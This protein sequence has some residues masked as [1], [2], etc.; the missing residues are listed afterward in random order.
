QRNDESREGTERSTPACQ[1]VPDQPPPRLTEERAEG[2]ELMSTVAP[3][4]APATTGHGATRP[5]P[6][7]TLSAFRSGPLTYG[8]LVI[9][10]A[11]FMVPLVFVISIALA[12]D[13]SVSSGQLTIFPRDWQFSNF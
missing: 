9:L 4:P 2:D 1:P 8:L 11:I 12:S 5:A 10:S 7:R 3:A 13:T 6:P